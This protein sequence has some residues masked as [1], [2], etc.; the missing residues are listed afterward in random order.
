MKKSIS[1]FIALTIATFSLFSQKY[2]ADD[3]VGKWEI[4]NG[5]FHL[6]ENGKAKVK[7]D[8]GNIEWGT[9]DYWE[10]GYKRLDISLKDSD[11][12]LEVINKYGNSLTVRDVENNRRYTLHKASGVEPLISD[13][14]APAAPSLYSTPAPKPA[15]KKQS[16][17]NAAEAAGALILGAIL[18][19]AFLG[20]GSSSGGSK[21]SCSTCGGRGNVLS[22]NC[23]SGCPCPGCGG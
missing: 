5:Y 22:S 15:P 3:F 1:L 21:A 6:M 12:K 18:L 13:T 19:D 10:Y 17:V 4:D 7:F 8:N 9:W 2:Y 11:A 14:A 23:P 16:S 20:S